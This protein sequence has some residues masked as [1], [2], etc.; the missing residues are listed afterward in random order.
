MQL[1]FEDLIIFKDWM[2]PLP[3]G[4]AGRVELKAEGE[5]WDI[6]LKMLSTSL[7]LCSLP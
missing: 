7:F 3:E 6:K 2:G 1:Y 5:A 4:G